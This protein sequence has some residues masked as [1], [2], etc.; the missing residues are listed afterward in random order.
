VIPGRWQGAVVL[1]SPVYIAF[2]AV[3]ISVWMGIGEPVL[4]YL[5]RRLEY[6]ADRFYLRSGGSL[7]EMQ[8][9][10][11][12]LARQNLARTEAMRRRET[13][14]HPLPSISNRLHRARA[15]ESVH[16]E[17]EVR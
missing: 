4:A 15:F 10:L 9:A 1:G 8:R 14:F 11:D 5:G 2:L 13:I 7:A 12:E 16:S 6:Q 17:R 3:T